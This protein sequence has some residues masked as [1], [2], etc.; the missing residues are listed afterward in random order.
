MDNKKILIVLIAVIVAIIIIIIA[1]FSLKPKNNEENDR[2]L[3][4]TVSDAGKVDTSD[5]LSINIVNTDEIKDK[6]NNYNKFVEDLK[7]YLNENGIIN[8]DTLNMEQYQENN[9]VLKIRFKA[10]DEN[11]TNILVTINLS[12]NTYSF[13]NYR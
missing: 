13:N 10:N 6:I 9:G 5:R 11:Q 12:E 3:H 1:I 8:F 7:K 2:Y 4:N